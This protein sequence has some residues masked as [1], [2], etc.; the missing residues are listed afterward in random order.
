MIVLAKWIGRLE[1]QRKSLSNCQWAYMKMMLVSILLLI[2][3]W[4]IEYFIS[5]F[6]L[7][8]FTNMYLK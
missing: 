7:R 1:D 4:Y 3:S 6:H 5:R 8:G 2:Q